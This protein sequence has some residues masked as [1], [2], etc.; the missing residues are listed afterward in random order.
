MAISHADHN[1]PNTPTARAACRKFMAGTGKAPAKAPK[2]KVSPAMAAFLRH[3]GLGE[4]I[5]STPIATTVRAAF[6]D[7]LVS[8]DSEPVLTDKGWAAIGGRPR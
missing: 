1:H 6:R 2:V 4:S 7:G 3:W 8:G 5:A